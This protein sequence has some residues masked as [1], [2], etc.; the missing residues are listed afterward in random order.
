MKK[1]SFNNKIL[2]CCASWEC[3][4]IGWYKFHQ[5]HE[6][7]K[8]ILCASAG[9]FGYYVW[10]GGTRGANANINANFPQNA[11][12]TV[13]ITLQ[14]VQSFYNI[15]VGNLCPMLNIEIQCGIDPMGYVTGSMPQGA[16][17]KAPPILARFLLRSTFILSQ[18]R[19]LIL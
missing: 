18:E 9:C 1:P 15:F 3:A 17:R 8:T 19:F 16:L 6:I 14:L 5:H 7:H 13:S 11:L 10:G 4:F 12:N 2:F